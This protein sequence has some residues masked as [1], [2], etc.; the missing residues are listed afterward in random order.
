MDYLPQDI[1]GVI[2]MVP[3]RLYNSTELVNYII[4]ANPLN[5]NFDSLANGSAIENGAIFGYHLSSTISILS[6]DVVLN[7]QTTIPSPVE[8]MIFY[9]KNEEGSGQFYGI[10][11]DTSG[12][13]ITVAL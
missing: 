7:P 5:S 1:R 10:A 9:L 8:G 2:S 13:L 4:D 11:S 3:N 12:N 6:N